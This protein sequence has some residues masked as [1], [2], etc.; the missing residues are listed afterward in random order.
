VNAA[1]SQLRA[2]LRECSFT[3]LKDVYGE[4]DPHLARALQDHKEA[5]GYVGVL[6]KDSDFLVY[7]GCRYVPF[8]AVTADPKDGHLTVSLLRRHI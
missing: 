8:D 7:Q 4:A 2:A 6:G 5:K 3:I 1:A